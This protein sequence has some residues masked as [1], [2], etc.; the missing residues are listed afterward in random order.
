LKNLSFHR[1]TFKLFLPVVWIGFVL[2]GQIGETQNAPVSTAG[3]ISGYESQMAV[4]LTVSDFNFIGSCNLRML[5]DPAV[6]MATSVSI[7]S[8]VGG[9]ISFNVTAPGVIS[10][11]WFTYP[12]ISLTDN[13]VVFY[14][15]FSKVGNG[16]TSSLAW[17]DAAGYTCEWSNGNYVVL[18]D[19]P[20]ASYYLNGSFSFLSLNAPVTSLPTVE[21]LSGSLLEI[22][23]TVSAF[24]N[25][26][27]LFLTLHYNSSSLTFNGYLNDSGFP[28]LTAM[29]QSPGV[30]NIQGYS[31]T[32]GVNLPDETVLITLLFS[33]S[34]G[35][36]ALQWFD[37]GASCEYKRY[38]DLL[39]L[40]DN[41][42]SAYYLN[43]SVIERIRFQLKVFLEGPYL[44]GQMTAGLNDLDLIPMTQPFA[45]QPW[46]YNGTEE[47]LTIPENAVDWVLVDWRETTG[48]ASTA[49]SDKSLGRKAGFLM[50][51]G[52]VKGL[53]GIQKPDLA[54]TP[55]GNLYLV[56][57]HRNH[58][59]VLSANAVL[60]LNGNGF[61]DF[62]AGETQVFGGMLGHKM[63]S[64]GIWGMRGGDGDA[65]EQ[66]DLIDK[67]VIWSSSS[68]T[69]GYLKA[70]FNL[71]GQVNNSDKNEI[72]LKNVGSFSQLP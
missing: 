8:G 67:D 30:L 36:S 52:T 55:A 3:N 41:P 29:G 32:F 35:T 42:S 40:N 15:H 43:G 44:N 12:G 19:L 56:L 48:G 66:I 31:P 6:A 69:K 53:D 60:I 57:Y 27:S 9:N 4:P 11:G 45:A 54:Y 2:S 26:G 64:L 58:L 28:G 18:N 25:I 37:D 70:D 34:G 10:W 13:S 23:V 22:P 17:D 47:V 21:A 61:Y 5:Y 14:V 24:S 59:P 72:W 65:D 51:D 38:P 49:T 33:Y 68:G 46:N 7:A 50:K 1:L 71:D 62:S 16:G 63:L 39:P 20:T